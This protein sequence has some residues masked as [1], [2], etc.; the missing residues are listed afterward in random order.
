MWIQDHEPD[1]FRRTHQTLCA[2]DYINLRLT[3]EVATD[4]SDASGTN[5]FDLNTLPL[6]GARS[7]TWRAST[8]RCFRPPRPSTDML[9]TVTPAAAAGDRAAG[10]HAGGRGRRRRQLRRRRRGLRPAGHGLQLPRLVQLDRP[11]RRE[12]DRR[13]ADADHELGPLRARLPASVGHH[14]GGRVQLPVAEEHG[15]HAAKQREAAEHGRGRVRADQP[16]DRALAARGRRRA[17]SCRTCWASARRAGTR[18]A[19]GAF[20][21]LSLATRREDLLRAVLEGITLNLGIIV[22]IFRQHVPI[23]AI[24]VIGGGAKGAVWRQMH[25]RRL[26][27]PRSRS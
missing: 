24:T 7:W 23:D 6:V 1:V 11:D 12:A 9:G 10:R 27:L 16:A 18:K 20:I 15:L 3:G 19:K 2:K 5:A 14:A 26:R 21:G 25:G 4:Y 8:P 22:N 13:S 17:S